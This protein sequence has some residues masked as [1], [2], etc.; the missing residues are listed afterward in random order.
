[1][2]RG[3]DEA[4]AMLDCPLDEQTQKLIYFLSKSYGVDFPLVMGLIERE[5]SFNPSAISE[6]GDF[7]LMQINTV[8]REMLEETLGITDLLDP[9]QNVRAGLFILGGLLERHHDPAKAL[10]AYNLGE[11]GAKVLWDKGICETGYTSRVLESAAKFEA[12]MANGRQANAESG[13][14]Q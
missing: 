11:S 13:T 9:G 10:M 3:G 8:N 5:S 2:E 7:G 6:T 4:F 12:E 1:L 14:V